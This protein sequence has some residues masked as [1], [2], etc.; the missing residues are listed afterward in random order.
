[1]TQTCMTRKSSQTYLAKVSSRIWHGKSKLT[2]RWQD[3]WVVQARLMPS[4]LEAEDEMEGTTLIMAASR[5]DI[6]TQFS[7]DHREASARSAGLKALFILGGDIAT[8]LAFLRR[9]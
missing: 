1:M 4:R 5:S 8:Y 3:R 9:L 7:E 6:A 2:A